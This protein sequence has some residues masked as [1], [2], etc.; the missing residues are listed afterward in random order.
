MTKTRLDRTFK[1]QDAELL[2]KLIGQFNQLLL[3]T[4]T[5]GVLGIVDERQAD[6]LVARFRKIREKE[7]KE[8][9]R[10]YSDEE[11]ELNKEFF[12]QL[13]T[14][15][16]EFVT[17]EGLGTEYD[18]RRARNFAETAAAFEKIAGD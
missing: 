3:W 7:G 8:F 16:N 10:A 6:E 17:R 9:P 4:M 13:Q 12:R 15:L 11:Y 14:L 1:Q 18:K 5:F 2:D